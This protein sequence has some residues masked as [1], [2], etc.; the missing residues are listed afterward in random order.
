VR[1]DGVILLPPVKYLGGKRVQ[2]YIAYG[3]GI[4]NNR[5]DEISV[6][7]FL[8]LSFC[9]SGCWFKYRGIHFLSFEA[10]DLIKGTTNFYFFNST[11]T[12]NTLSIP[13][14]SPSLYNHASS[15]QRHRLHPLNL[16]PLPS[17]HRL[18]PQPRRKRPLPLPL[19]PHLHHPRPP[20]MEVQNMVFLAFN[21][22]WAGSRSS[23]V[24]W[25]SNDAF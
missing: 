13:H 4:G 22:E 2:C 5:A 10:E 8:Y 9:F 25:A 14:F 6:G 11:S 3:D 23:G 12:T 18:R 19:H 24:C 16:S 1:E 17:N 15:Q 21:D 20:T 7:L